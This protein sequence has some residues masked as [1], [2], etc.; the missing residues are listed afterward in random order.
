MESGHATISSK[1]KA[2]NTS[3]SATTQTASPTTANATRTF[4]FRH[5][6]TQ[7]QMALRGEACCEEMG[8]EVT[9]VARGFSS[10]LSY[11]CEAASGGVC[12]FPWRIISH[13]M[14]PMPTRQANR[15]KSDNMYCTGIALS[16]VPD[17]DLMLDY[18]I[19]DND[20]IVK[21]T[22]IHSIEN[23]RA[24]VWLERTFGV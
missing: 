24:Y 17:V 20:T 1:G 19:G 2:V 3:C 21:G 18:S 6:C 7:S 10:G 15:G 8:F 9:V 4:Q 12:S 5:I 14:R 16:S 22:I 11:P 23:S 13:I